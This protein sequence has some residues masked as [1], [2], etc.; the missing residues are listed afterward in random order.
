MNHKCKFP[1]HFIIW[2]VLSK[3]TKCTNVKSILTWEH[4]TFFKKNSWIMI[5]YMSKIVALGQFLKIRCGL[6]MNN[7]VTFSIV[8]IHYKNVLLWNPWM[9]FLVHPSL[10]LPY[11][12]KKKKKCSSPW[13][14]DS[15]YNKKN[16]KVVTF[17]L[18]TK[19]YYLSNSKLLFQKESLA[20]W[21]KL[22]WISKRLALDV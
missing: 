6:G 10:Q 21:K 4:E 12:K 1:C 16:V 2:N 3:V 7:N 15:W 19:F 13:N 18:H 20:W 5:I 22:S 17:K 14:H 9:S 8:K 11:C